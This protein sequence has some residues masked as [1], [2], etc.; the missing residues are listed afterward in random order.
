M[1]RN[2]IA[3]TRSYRLLN[4]HLQRTGFY[5]F[6]L[7][8]IFKL[9]ITVT[10]F[11]VFLLILQKFIPDISLLVQQS[12]GKINSFLVFGMYYV[13]QSLMG[14]LPTNLF[15][16]WIK[17]FKH[18]AAMLFVLSLLSYAGGITAY[19]IGYYSN[20]SKIIKRLLKN[21]SNGIVEKT[22]KWGGLL[23]MISAFLPLPYSFICIV[24]GVVRFPLPSF[25]LWSLARIPKFFVMA[26]ALNMVL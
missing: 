8:N 19:L 26:V 1:Q 16:I 5:I 25:L 10:L 13:S 24:T 6:L 21:K 14:F 3:I 7:K 23:I 15:I 18:P 20:N 2:A 17:T 11:L 12:I 9:L 22:N 4:I